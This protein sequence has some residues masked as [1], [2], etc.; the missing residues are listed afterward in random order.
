MYDKELIDKICN[1]T[2]KPEEIDINQTSIKYDSVDSFNKY[3][4]VNTIINAIDKYIN[5]EWNDKTLANWCCLYDWIIEGGCKISANKNLNELEYF[6]KELIS[7]DLDGL[8]FF[9]EEYLEDDF[10]FDKDYFINLD[11]ILKNNNDWKGIYAPIGECDEMNNNQ[12]ALLF[13]DK[14]KEYIII[15]SN[16]F[17]Y[18]NYKHQNV[19]L[20]FTTKNRFVNKLNDLKDN[21][22]K[23]IE[24]DEKEF[25]DDLYDRE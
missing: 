11:Y 25:Y 2:C 23:L 21:N 12:Y 9:D 19:Y 3:Y 4:N 1:L 5:K 13:N 6:I 18:N 17:L 22:Y 7:W 20:R 15:F 16:G 14:L 24:C 8:S 10:M